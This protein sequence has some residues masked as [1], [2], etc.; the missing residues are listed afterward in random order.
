MPSAT[1]GNT[2]RV[3][4]LLREGVERA[5]LAPERRVLAGAGEF[6][7]HKEVLDRVGFRGR[8]AQ[9]DRLPIVEQLRLLGREQP[10]PQGRPGKIV[11]AQRAVG[12]DDRAVRPHPIRM[13]AAAGEIPAA[14]HPV[15]ARHRDPPAVVRRPPGAGR[16]RVA[17]HDARRLRFEVGGEEPDAVGDRHAPA[18]RAVGPRQ[19][20]DRLDIGCRLDLVA[21]DRAR[22]EHPEEPRLVQRVEH[23]LGQPPVALDR[24][25]LR[26]DQSRQITRSR[27][28]AW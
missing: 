22:I 9:P 20:S 13:A 24:V 8:A 26:G 21:A 18:D 1:L 15:A 19:L 27:C 3:E 16:A 28:G 6:L 12:L 4:S 17:E 23:R 14:R 25:R 5:R 11:E 7:G 10:G 2:D